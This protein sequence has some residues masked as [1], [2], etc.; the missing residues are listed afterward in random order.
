MNIQLEAARQ[1]RIAS[2]PRAD[3]PDV[4]LVCHNY[5]FKISGER[6]PE[7][8]GEDWTA[9]ADQASA[10][11]YA[12]DVFAKKEAEYL[13]RITRTPDATIE[14]VVYVSGAV[15]TARAETEDYDSRLVCGNSVIW[16]N[17]DTTYDY[18][19]S[20][21]AVILQHGEEKG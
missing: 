21:D 3:G 1:K 9:F 10:V 16:I 13:Q 11:A 17:A 15:P 20:P 7:E 19:Y 8:D 14:N 18:I 6:Y 2:V 5:Y 4:Y 12:S